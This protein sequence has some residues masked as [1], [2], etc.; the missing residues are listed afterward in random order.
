[1]SRYTSIGK[2]NFILKAGEIISSGIFPDLT[3]YLCGDNTL[4]SEISDSGHSEI[5]TISTK[6][7]IR[8]PKILSPYSSNTFWTSQLRTT[9]LQRAR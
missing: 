2:L 3:I 6:D 4:Y 5:R 8:S 9:S 1:M 7:P